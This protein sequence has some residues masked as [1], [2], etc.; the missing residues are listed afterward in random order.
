[1]FCDGAAVEAGVD[2]WGGWVVWVVWVGWGVVAGFAT[3]VVVAPAAPTPAVVGVWELTVVGVGFGLPTGR[4]GG[5]SLPLTLV[6]ASLWNAVLRHLP[7]AAGAG[8]ITPATVDASASRP[9][10]VR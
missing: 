4:C 6:P 10:V 7:G 8:P 5:V 2:D 1:V 3:V 9:S